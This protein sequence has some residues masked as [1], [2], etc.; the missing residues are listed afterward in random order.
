MKTGECDLKIKCST[1]VEINLTAQFF[2]P[3]VRMECP[4]RIQVRLE[5]E[6]LPITGVESEACEITMAGSK[7]ISAVIESMVDEGS[8]I[9]LDCKVM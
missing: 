3:K 8:Q 1:F 2:H 9:C 4:E 5:K 6:H 7:P